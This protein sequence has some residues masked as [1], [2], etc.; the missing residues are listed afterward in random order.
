MFRTIYQIL[1]YSGV[2]NL[3]RHLCVL[4]D[5]FVF[6]KKSKPSAKEKKRTK[7]L[8]LSSIIHIYIEKELIF[9]RLFFLQTLPTHILSFM[10]RWTT[11]L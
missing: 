8:K 7:N 3:A 1:I 2:L 5:F 9:I 11:V 6:N 4:K 10:I